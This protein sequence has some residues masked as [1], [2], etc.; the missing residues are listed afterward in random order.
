MIPH[1]KK[2]TNRKLILL[3]DD[4]TSLSE[5]I[6]EFLKESSFDVISENDPEKA[7]RLAR[8]M[9]VDLLILDL[10]MPK[11]DGF[12]VL[13][14]VREH[15]P[16]VKVIILT[17][18]ISEF[19]EQLKQIKVDMLMMKP[20]DT[21]KLL[22][23]IDD[24]TETIAYEPEFGSGDSLVPKAKILIVDDE[25]EYCEIVSDYL[26]TYL[27]AKFEVE[28][29]QSGLE[30]IEK[31]SFFEPDFVLMDWKMP[32]M[33]GDEF[34]SKLTTIE[35]WAPKQIFV[36][37]GS[38]LTPKERAE[39]PHGTL[40][41]NKPFDLEQFCDSAPSAKGGL[42]RWR[43]RPENRRPPRMWLG[44]AGHRRNRGRLNPELRDR[45]TWQSCA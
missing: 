14:L 11:L 5:A 33:R 43:I 36:I 17:G 32:H 18:K 16:K 3:V 39:L 8:H 27:K 26:R 37:S 31:A 4:D 42:R 6:S 23:A 7:V 15:Q 2:R 9:L 24:L 44:C 41:F 12:E 21:E 38:S 29:A 45:P 25:I 34:L 20:P 1:M 19:Q 10:Q 13:K 22:T 28:F 35:D 40:V 30:G